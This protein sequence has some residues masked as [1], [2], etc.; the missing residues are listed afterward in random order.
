MPIGMPGCPEFAFCTAS[1]A[2][3]RI[4]LASSVRGATASAGCAAR[5]V[6]SGICMATFLA[7]VGKKRGKCLKTLHAARFMRLYLR[8][9]H[10]D[11]FRLGKPLQEGFRPPPWV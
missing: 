4:A 8:T 7:E 5:A 3:A 10:R 2:R 9:F 1:I 11:I 6:R